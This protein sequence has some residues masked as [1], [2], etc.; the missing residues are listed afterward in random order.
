MTRPI[1]IAINAQL[2]PGRGVGG[3]GTVLTG[4][5]A[6]LGRL[7]DGQDEFIIISPWD[8]PDW[9]RP[10]MGPNQSIVLGPRLAVEKR[11]LDSFKRILGP[12]RPWA[13]KTRRRLFPGTHAPA[14]SWPS[15]T[16]SDGFYESLG[17]DV[18][19][20]PW[21]HFV[22]C[23][24]PT[25]YNPHDLQ[26]LHYPQFFTPNTIALR[27]SQWPVACRLAHTVVVG[28][29]WIKEDI[30]RQYHVHSTKLQVI[31]WAAPTQVYPEP[32][33]DDLLAV[34]ARY[35]LQRPFAYYP[36]STYHHKNHLRLLEA[37]A[38]LRD[39]EQM[40]VNLVC[41][42]IRD[43]GVWPAVEA[44]LRRLQLEEQVHFLGVVP[45]PDLRAFYRLAQ[46][47]IFPTLFEGA[48]LPAFEAL[49]EGTPLACS[50]VTSLPE[51]VGDAA[52]LFDPM[53]VEAI[54]KVLQCLTLD[55]GLRSKLAQKGRQRRQIF[56]W[57]L[58]ARAYRAVYRKAGRV[59]LSEEDR[60]LL[61]WD[62]LRGTQPDEVT[63]I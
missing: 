5:I 59:Q 37:V 53:S 55:E 40:I 31:P 19:H 24:L 61:Q 21:Q 12:L 29:Q 43:P 52:L 32:T 3:V 63:P 11:K 56:N 60:W 42:G 1:R 30:V 35:N 50:N 38:L 10:F 36:A 6:A 13:R 14:P 44:S 49:Q 22:L 8:E 51:E 7:M 41:T 25:I 20:F 45:G 27:E 15:L 2:V 9:P 16:L 33:Q 23:A 47:V 48:G 46:F 18:V 17:C 58:T 34:R 39:K 62:W 57:E 28:S 26:H 4:L 54:A